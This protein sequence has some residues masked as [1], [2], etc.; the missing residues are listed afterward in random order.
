MPACNPVVSS[1][2]STIGSLFT[3][4]ATICLGIMLPFHFSPQEERQVAVVAPPTMSPTRVKCCLSSSSPTYHPSI[5]PPDSMY[6]P[7]SK[8]YKGNDLDRS[9]SE[10]SI[11]DEA[12]VSASKYRRASDPDVFST[13]SR[14]KHAFSI[15][16]SCSIV[17][18]YNGLGLGA[19][20]T[21]SRDSTPDD[22]GASP[23]WDEDNAICARHSL[24]T[25]SE[26]L[27]WH[28]SQND[29]LVNSQLV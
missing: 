2:R 19:P 5:S 22:S 27:P 6:L 9:N 29:T 16:A 13:T 17:K 20:S 18:R 14:E 3:S 7:K 11:L 15:S 8:P 26:F 25:L 1:I 12:A 21:R 4:R 10:T 23:R 24:L 28:P